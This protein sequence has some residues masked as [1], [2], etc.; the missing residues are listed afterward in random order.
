MLFYQLCQISSRNRSTYIKMNY[1]H[2]WHNINIK[3]CV[4]LGKNVNGIE[5]VK[6]SHAFK[7]H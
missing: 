6:K 5:D 4:T 2:V 1:W 7:L 3:F